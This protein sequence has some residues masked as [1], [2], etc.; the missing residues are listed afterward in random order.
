[1]YKVVIFDFDG[2]ICSSMA[3]IHYCMQATFEHFG[4]EAP[5]LNAVAA[6][7]KKGSN[8][9]DSFFELDSSLRHLSSDQLTQWEAAYRNTY[10]AADHTK[11]QLYTGVTPMLHAIGDAGIACVIVSNKNSESIQMTLRQH[12]CAQYFSE[13]YG[14]SI[15]FPPKPDPAL[16]D[17]E[18]HP[19]FPGYAK[20]DFLMVGDTAVDYYFAMA[21]GIDMAW[22]DYGY[23]SI[24]DIDASRLK[25]QLSKPLDLVS[26]LGL[27]QSN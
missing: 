2:T 22:V 24:D 25:F 17:R 10:R 1:M 9:L 7:C 20:D 3:L 4:R 8:L 21:C 13:I 11:A 23:G 16:F 6:M 18:I 26:A 15:H 27:P 5:S 19:S 12:D 14:T